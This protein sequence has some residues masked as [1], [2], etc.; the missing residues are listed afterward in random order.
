MQGPRWAV[1]AVVGVA[2]AGCLTPSGGRNGYTT[3]GLAHVAAIFCARQA[4]EDMGYRVVADHPSQERFQ[5]SRLFPP[6]R[7]DMPP[8]TGYLAVSVQ[9]S[10]ERGRLLLVHASRVSRGVPERR[11]GRPTPPEG[12]Y[13]LPPTGMDTL[14]RTGRSNPRPGQ[15]MP[16][17]PVA[18]DA[19]RV[20]DRCSQRLA[21]G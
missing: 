2:A 9:E 6:D 19:G 3:R 10:E 8:S 5:A 12:G 4:V 18:H 1:L 11:T 20:V 21:S 14:P 7:D 13:P 16:P 17:G 15:Q